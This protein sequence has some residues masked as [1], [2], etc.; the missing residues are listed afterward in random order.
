VQVPRKIELV[1]GNVVYTTVE[2]NRNKLII[3]IAWAT[4]FRC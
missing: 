2:L 1:E 4:T 3:S